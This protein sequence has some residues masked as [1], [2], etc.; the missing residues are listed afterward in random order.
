MSN[1]TSGTKPGTR[2]TGSGV[3]RVFALALSLSALSCHAYSCVW[4]GHYRECVGWFSA[5]QMAARLL[6]YSSVPVAA[7]VIVGAGIAR[8][9]GLRSRL[10]TAFGCWYLGSLL[11]GLFLSWFIPK[12][13]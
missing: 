9:F 2:S 6:I 4:V 10:G 5:F 7:I 8:L 13:I 1:Q 11:I 12:I 3:A